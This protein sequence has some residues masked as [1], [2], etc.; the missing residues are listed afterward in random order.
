MVWESAE[1][2]IFPVQIAYNQAIFVAVLG[3]IWADPAM[4]I[5]GALLVGRWSFGLLRSTAEILLDRE[6]ADDVRDTVREAIEAE[7]DNRV[8]DLHVWAVAPNLYSSII[9]VVTKFPRPPD[10][11]KAMIP[12]ETR[13]VHAVVEVHACD[14]H[15]LP[16]ALKDIRSEE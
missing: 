2:F 4:G 15:G 1:R 10:H 6:A 16:L 12:T 3:L 14:E 7:D 8:A 5:V 9:S 13:V 11:Y